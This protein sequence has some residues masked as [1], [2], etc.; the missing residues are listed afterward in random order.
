MSPP[1]ALTSSDDPLPHPHSGARM[2]RVSYP[3]R[4]SV[5]CALVLVR[6]TQPGRDS[7]HYAVSSAR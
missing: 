5:A 1:R 6:W 2:C 3:A 7:Y 4:Q